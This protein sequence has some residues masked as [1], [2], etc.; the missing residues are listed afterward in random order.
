MGE[1]L[2][3]SIYEVSKKVGATTTQLRYYEKEFDCLKNI[4]KTNSG[5]RKYTK[6]NIENIQLILQLIKQKGY[7]IKGANKYIN[8][9]LKSNLSKIETIDKL[10]KVRNFLIMLKNSL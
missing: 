1:K 3:Y 9:Q 6:Q 2:F 5:V 10:E 4:Y 8:S 7:T